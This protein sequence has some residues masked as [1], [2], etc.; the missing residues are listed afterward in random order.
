MLGEHKRIGLGPGRESECGEAPCDDDWQL[1]SPEVTNS[2][3][4][5]DST[6]AEVEVK[7]SNGLVLILGMSKQGDSWLVGKLAY[8]PS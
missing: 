3:V 2:R 7:G 4:F 8:P 5:D 1:P 6:R